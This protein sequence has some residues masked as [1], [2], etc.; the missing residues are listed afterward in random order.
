MAE[1]HVLA[2]FALH[3]PVVVF[4]LYLPAAAH[5]TDD[6]D[7]ALDRFSQDLTIITHSTPGSRLLGGA[8]LNTQLAP[9]G[10]RIGKHVGTGERSWEGRRNTA[11][12]ELLTHHDLRVSS[13]FAPYPSTRSPWP[14]QTQKHPTVIDF[15]FTSPDVQTELWPY[16]HIHPGVRSDHRPIGLAATAHPPKRHLWKIQWNNAF[17]P[18]VDWN[19]HIP[20]N[21]QPTQPGQWARDLRNMHFSNLED[22][23]PALIQAT[24]AHPSRRTPAIGHKPHPHPLNMPPQRASGHSAVIAK[25][26]GGRKRRHPIPSP[27]RSPVSPHKNSCH[28]VST[29]QRHRLPITPPPPPL[30]RRPGHHVA[31]RGRSQHP[32]QVSPHQPHDT[33]TKTIH[34]V[35]SRTMLPHN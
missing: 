30:A 22:L 2:S 1:H 21:W 5:G 7:K 15:L 24:K 18:P 10:R 35:A 29:R 20:T 9:F 6:F 25:P 31:Q 11:L 13:T 26:Q 34:A 23:A 16:T 28:T 14:G 3:P 8:D 4:S 12:R 33:A 27:Q 17:A 19:N 32:I